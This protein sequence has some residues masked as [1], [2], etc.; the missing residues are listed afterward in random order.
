MAN[1]YTKL[2]GIKLGKVPNG[3]ICT[4]QELIR[5]L[6]DN[7]QA[8]KFFT[9]IWSGYTK[10]IRSQCNKGRLMDSIYFGTFFKKEN[11]NQALKDID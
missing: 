10:F 6:M 3:A 9:R 7:D 8:H 5:L 2:S 1:K 11:D 4:E